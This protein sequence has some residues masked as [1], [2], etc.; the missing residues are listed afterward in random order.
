VG[1]CDGV[2]EHFYLI[3]AE[4]KVQHPLVQQLL[5]IKR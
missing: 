3:V 4:K 1:A 5:R 2:E